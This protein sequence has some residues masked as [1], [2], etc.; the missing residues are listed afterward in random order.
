MRLAFQAWAV[1]LVLLVLAFSVAAQTPGDA[2]AQAGQGDAAAAQG[3]FDSP[4]AVMQAFLQAM[5]RVTDGDD[6]AYD[7]ALAT[8]NFSRVEADAQRRAYADQLYAVFDRLGRIDVDALPDT[9]DIARVGDDRP[10]LRRW[11]FF[12]K[13][14]HEWVYEALGSGQAPEGQIVFEVDQGGSWRFGAPTVAGIPALYESLR[15]LPPRYTA[16]RSETVTNLLS[17]LG[18]TFENTPGWAWLALLGAIFFGLLVGKLLQIAL[19]S[20][21]NRWEQR[22]WYVR[23]VVL[24]DAASP[25]SF[26]MLSLGLMVG[27][28]FI[29]MQPDMRGFANNIITFLLII[30][31]G[32]Y[33][34]NLVDVIDAA[35]RRITEKTESKLDDQ[36]VPLIRKSLR[37][38][39]VIVFGLLVAQN[40]FGLNI[41]SWLAGL[42]I[43]GLAVSLAAQDSVKNLFGSIT[44]FF[45]KPFVL[46]DFIIFD[47]HMG[48]V[49]EIGFR[50]TRLRLLSGH[51]VTVP[52]MKFI[53]GTVENISRRPYIR[54]EMNV[55]IT[56]DTP[57]ENIE[58]AVDIVRDILHDPEVIEVGRFDMEDKPPRIAF[59]E[60]NADSLNIRAYYWYQMAGDPDRGFFTFIEHSQIVNMKLFRAFGEAGIDFAFP[61]QT[62]YLAGDPDRELAVKVLGS[63]EG[64]SASQ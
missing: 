57:P 40:V 1:G 6:D 29:H 53:D 63:G 10:A 4:Q 45:D 44:V 14:E 19:R 17:I 36:L 50:S 41:T 59:N 5:V 49:E 52:N 28:G 38:F 54:R 33:L 58:R 25:V 34:Y 11:K 60:L 16:Q 30:A 27:M 23:G 43:A 47:G 2:D 42:G 21:G 3:T 15:P 48:D 24:L 12:P 64:E 55:T 26:L 22:G 56:Y 62:V 37:I 46:G 32:W 39:L 31:L 7:N 20:V 8:M 9:H 18:P 51:L 35:L 13:P 61:S